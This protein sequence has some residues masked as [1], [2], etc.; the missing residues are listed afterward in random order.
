MVL[1]ELISRSAACC[2]AFAVII[3]LRIAGPAVEAAEAHVLASDDT[4]VMTPGPG[5]IRTLRV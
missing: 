4:S 3:E 2:K 5:G 1:S